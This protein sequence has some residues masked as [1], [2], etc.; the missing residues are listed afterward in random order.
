[1]RLPYPKWIY[2]GDPVKPSSLEEAVGIIAGFSAQIEIHKIQSLSRYASSGMLGWDELHKIYRIIGI[3]LNHISIL[4]LFGDPLKPIARGSSDLDYALGSIA[5]IRDPSLAASITLST[6]I[7]AYIAILEFISS[8]THIEKI[9]KPFSEILVGEKRSLEELLEILSKRFKGKDAAEALE[10]RAVVLFASA[11]AEDTLKTAIASIVSNTILDEASA[12]SV[13]G[14]L[15]RNIDKA[16]IYAAEKLYIESEAIVSTISR[17]G[18]SG[19]A[20]C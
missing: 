16:R 1:M 15:Y 18:L 17:Y 13:L 5:E 20:L 11:A 14:D 4:S 19:L 12:N 2:I 6:V 10:E 3:D 8:K 9:R 7:P